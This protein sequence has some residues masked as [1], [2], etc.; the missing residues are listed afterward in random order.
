MD[1]LRNLFGVS[2]REILTQD[3]FKSGFYFSHSDII[4][5]KQFNNTEIESFLFCHT[6]GNHNGFYKGYQ[7]QQRFYFIQIEILLKLN[8]F[9]KR[10]NEISLSSKV[11]TL[12]SSKMLII[13]QHFY[14]SYFPFQIYSLFNANLYIITLKQDIYLFYLK[15]KIVWSKR[16]CWDWRGFQ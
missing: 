8:L 7:R 14:S 2:V 13:V 15:I 4:T 1:F 6:V 5:Q 16:V 10:H 9:R 3:Q 11:L 12:F